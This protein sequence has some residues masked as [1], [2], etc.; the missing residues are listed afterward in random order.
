MA[1]P[2]ELTPEE[3]KKLRRQ[4]R[5]AVG[6]VSERIHF[7]L[8]RSRGYS[9]AQIADLYQI[10][11]RT[12]SHWLECYQAAGLAGLD[13]HPR[14]GRPRRA[15]AA[16]AADCHPG[17][18]PQTARLRLSGGADG[19][20]ALLVAGPEAERGVPDLPACALSLVSNR[21]DPVHPG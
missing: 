12:V 7:V 13:D 14:S 16:A 15:G 20:V 5:R 18:Q 19:G 4:A 11:E 8:L 3:R 2:L 10:E 1:L 21:P 9:L 6:R 17:G